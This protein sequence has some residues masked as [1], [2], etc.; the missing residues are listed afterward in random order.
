[1]Q[2]DLKLNVF[3]HKGDVIR[4]FE[5]HFNITF[6]YN[7]LNKYGDGKKFTDYLA[8]ILGLDDDES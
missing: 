1:M 5:K 6:Y 7:A 2:D 8:I 3:S 4:H